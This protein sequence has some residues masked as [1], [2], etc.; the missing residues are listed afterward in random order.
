MAR[1]TLNFECYSLNDLFV[2]A[3]CI[4]E[5][6]KTSANPVALEFCLRIVSYAI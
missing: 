5:D 3:L 6:L 4:D 2:E 1:T